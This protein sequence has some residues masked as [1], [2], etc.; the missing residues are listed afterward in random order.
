MVARGAARCGCGWR[1]PRASIATCTRRSLLSTLRDGDRL[2]LSR[3]GPWTSGCPRPSGRSSRRR[4]SRCSTAP[5]ADLGE[6]V[7]PRRTTSGGSTRRCAEVE[8]QESRG[9]DWS[10]ASSSRPS[11]GRCDDGKLYTLDPCPNDWYGY[12]CAKVVE[13]LCAGEPNALYDRLRSPAARTAT[14]PAAAAGQARFLAGLDAFHAAGQLH[15]FEAEQ[16]GVHRRARRGRR[17]CWSRGRP[18]P[19]RATPPPSPSSPGSRGRW[20]RA[21]TSG[22]SSPARPTP[23]PTCCWRTSLEVREKLRGLASGRPEALRAALR[24]PAA[25]RAALPG[26]PRAT[27]RRTASSTLAQGR[28]RRR[29]ASRRNADVIQASR[30]CVVGDHARRHLRDAQEEVAEGRLRPRAL[31]L[32]GAGRGSPDEPARGDHGGAAAEAGR[33]ADRRRRPPADAADRQARLGRASPPH[34]PGVPG[35]REPVRHAAARRTRR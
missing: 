12:W 15:D 17:S 20:R 3:A 18:A 1:R 6:I 10:Q 33:P 32:P 9:G 31:R 22:S 34:L 30:W 21:A 19:A 23:P 8:L 11:T 2:V 27:R 29:R 14:W 7:R 4:R 35:L 16:A 25:R 28:P 24:R 13:G 5:R 26:A